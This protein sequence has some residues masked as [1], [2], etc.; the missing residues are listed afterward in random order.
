VRYPGHALEELS[1]AGIEYGG[2]LPN[3]RV[4]DAFARHRVTLHIPRSPYRSTL[5]GIPTTRPFEAMACG[6]P[7]ISAPWCDRENLFRPGEDFL[8]AR[9]GQEMT[10]HLQAV[11]GSAGLADSLAA[12]GLETIRRRHTCTHRAHQL[13][14]IVEEAAG[15]A[16][17]QPS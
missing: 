9:D 4:P 13:L 14:G 6:I 8:M 10:S 17:G 7:L 5:H 11:L 12:S 15:Q 3:Y 16:S 2:W 1:A